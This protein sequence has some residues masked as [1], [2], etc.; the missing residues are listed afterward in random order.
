MTRISTV[1]TRSIAGSGNPGF[2]TDFI[3]SLPHGPSTVSRSRAC[4]STETSPTSP[5]ASATNPA[6]TDTFV[7]E[8]GKIVS[9]TFA[10]YA[11][12]SVVHH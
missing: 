6:G 11:V 9:Q 1:K 3:A 4:K 8:N 10:M 2:F 7:V 12:T 5:G